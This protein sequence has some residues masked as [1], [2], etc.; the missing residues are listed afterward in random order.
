MWVDSATLVI[1]KEETER[2][3]NGRRTRAEER[4]LVALKL[5]PR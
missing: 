4:E 1:V 5:A 2:Q 3:T